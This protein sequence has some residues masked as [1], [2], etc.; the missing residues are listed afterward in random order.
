MSRDLASEAR[1][2]CPLE[3]CFQRGWPMQRVAANEWVSIQGCP[4]C[5]AGHDRFSVNTEKGI[6]FCRHCRNTGSAI[7][8][9]MAW[10]GVSVGEAIHRLVGVLPT[11]PPI[12][13]QRYA[14][15]YNQQAQDEQARGWAMG[16]WRETIPI[17][18][19]LGEIYLVKHRRVCISDCDLDG[20]VRFH[21]RCPMKEGDR[22]IIVP[23]LVCVFTSITDNRP[24]AIH[25]IGLAP[26]GRKLP[27]PIPK[28]YL[29]S[30][31]GAAIKIDPDEA[32]ET[33]LAV[34]EGVENAFTARMFNHRPCWALGDKNG[35][36]KLEVLP[37]IET[38]TIIL[39]HDLNGAAL[40]AAK[41]CS[42]RWHAAER[43][44]IEDLPPPGMDFNDLILKRAA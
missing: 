42:D 13:G 40:R 38:V 41:A 34:A 19:T 30:P 26:D 20:V 44:V 9:V 10:D 14:N 28:Q 17:K 24:V 21:P 39:D 11:T 12:L 31:H 15:E 16:I 6:F 4:I 1:S 43:T 5:Q 3:I 23:A 37:G 27:T 18:G 2:K 7:D 32:V 35:I 8:L 25:R 36:A 22:R 33:R 29:G